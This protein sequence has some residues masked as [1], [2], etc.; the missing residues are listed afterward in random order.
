MASTNFT[1]LTRALAQ[2]RIQFDSTVDGSA[3]TF[4]VL[5]VTSIPTEGNFDSWANRSDITNEVTAGGGYTTG[6]I[7]QAFTLDALDTTNNRQSVTWT[8]ITNG[9]TAATFGAAGAIIYR[10]SGT[11][12]TDTLLHFIDFGGTVTCTNG[13]FSITYSTPFYINR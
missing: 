5:L 9:W 4:K 6:G 8:N 10:N 13:S 11:S 2:G 7:A 1:S 3:D 12:T